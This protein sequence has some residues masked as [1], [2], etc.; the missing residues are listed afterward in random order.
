MP[1]SGLPEKMLIGGQL[2]ASA[3]GEWLE[4]VNPFDESYLGR[5]PMAGPEDADRA[6]KAAAD[7]APGWAEMT[8]GEREKI[9][10]EF[11]ERISER[12]EDFL[13]IEVRDTGNTITPMRKDVAMGVELLNYYAGLGYEAKGDTIPSSRN[14]LHVTIREPFG[15]VVKITPFNHPILFAISKTAAPLAAGNTVIVKPSETSPLSTALLAEVARDVFP[16]GVFNIVTGLG[17]VVGDALVRHPDIWRIGFTGSVATGLAIQRSAAEVGVKRVSLELGGKNPFIAFPDVDPARLAEAAVGGM[18]LTWQGQSCG[19]TSR[20]LLHEDIHDEVLERIEAIVSLLRL[21]NPMDDDTQ[22]GPVNSRSHHGRVMD[23]IEIANQDGAKLV[24]GGGRP[25]GAEFER[26]YW[27][28]PTIYSD[29]DA[30]MRIA[31]REVFGPVLSVLKWRDYEEAI[32]VANATQYGL[33]AAIWT[34]DITTAIKA[35]R[36]VQAGFV[37]VNGTSAHFTGVPFGGYKNSGVGNEES[38]DELLS[39]TQTKTIN[40][41]TS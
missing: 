17:S 6:V 40:F 26:G 39:Y 35:A 28:A 41:M 37:W 33:T 1:R 2:V 22:M 31:Q 32:K 16:A 19:S 13:N 18:N 34:S 25:R 11:A 38:I 12:A 9:M 21:G 36:G 24:T 8:P 23:L 5:V 27:V 4:S 10:R 3:S 20:L 15:P 14:N 30:D 29:V 7:A